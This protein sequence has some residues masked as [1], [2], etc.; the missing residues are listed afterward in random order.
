MPNTVEHLIEKI[1]SNTQDC[2]RF[3]NACEESALKHHQH[4]TWSAFDILEHLVL[5]DKMV[6]IM[7]RRPS[8]EQANSTNIIG[9]NILEDKIVQQR[10]LKLNAPDSLQ[11]K[12]LYTSR[13]A[14]EEAFL[15]IREKYLHDL[16]THQIVADNRIYKHPFLGN[17]T[18]SDWLLFIVYHNQRHLL[19]AQEQIKNA[20]I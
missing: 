9:E 2:I 4:A 17:M 3:L 10:N 14:C 15:K 11:P 5:T 18:V 20:T 19:Q 12:G 16:N 13:A 7:L 1:S 6:Y 8:N